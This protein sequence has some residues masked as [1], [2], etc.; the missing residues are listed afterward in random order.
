MS[1]KI[2]IIIGS[3]AT[4]FFGFVILSLLGMAGIIGSLIYSVIFAGKSYTISF[5]GTSFIMVLLF[6][7]INFFFGKN[8][9]E[10]WEDK[11]KEATK[12]KLKEN[13]I[14]TK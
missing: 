1:K 14:E 13:A 2:E 11:E 7:Y 10:A 4:M 3:L 12:S 9:L 8:L 5:Y 6:G